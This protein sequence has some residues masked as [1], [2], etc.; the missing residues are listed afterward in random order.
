MSLFKYS[1]LEAD[2]K[3]RKGIIEEIDKES[4][5][6][7]LMSQGLRP[8]EIKTHREEKKF[9]ISLG[10][11]ASQKLN[12]SDIDFFTTQIALLLNTGLSLD[13]SLRVMKQNSQKKAFQDFAWEIEHKLK[14]GKSFSEAL[15]D[16]PMFSSMYINIARAGEEGGVL[17][18]MLIKI[19]EYQKTFREL[20]QFV[21]SAS[22]YPLVL[23][24]VGLIAVLILITT[25]LPRFEVL[26]QGMGQQ[27]PFHVTVM[28]N[29]A[30]FVSNHIF[31]TFLCLVLPPVLII[32]YFKTDQGKKF[33]DEQSIKLPF[34][35]GF[36]KNLE[37][38]RI[39]RTLEVLVNNGVH[40]ATSLKIC[41]GVATNIEF[42]KLLKNATRALKEGQRIAP[43][44]Q[45]KGLF[46]ALA[47]DLL[48]IGEES[49]SVG[50]VCGQIADHYEQ[51]LRVRIKRLV[52][53]I[54]PVFIL[55]IA[56]VAGYIVISMLSVILSINEIAG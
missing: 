53:I 10:R 32:Y 22:I 19:S 39:F 56:V 52:A 29:F 28:M 4:A 3:I 49:G 30:K 7:H 54:E 11:F 20:T 5:A 50:E 13:A 17:P 44:L 12:R 8:L 45:G 38:S 16:Y 15:S 37:T 41:A 42:Q 47:V 35:S 24:A 23:M 9:S 18:K 6:K 36:I 2:N 43:K 51:E 40:L 31:I 26:F 14:E 25:I 33:F 27:L 21:L 34:I 55:M 1:A 46:P 48:A